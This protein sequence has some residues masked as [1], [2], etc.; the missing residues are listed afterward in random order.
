VE[1]RWLTINRNGLL[2][3]LVGIVLGAAIT[4][5]YMERKQAQSKEVFEHKN[6]C[7]QVAQ[8][9]EKEHDEGTYQLGISVDMLQ[10]E[11]S[12]ERNSCVAELIEEASNP[13]FKTKTYWVVDLLSAE[14]SFIG[15]CDE[16][17][18][19]CSGTFDSEMSSKQDAQFAEFRR[20]RSP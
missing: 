8:R 12:P 14:K 1:M 7:L 11:Y 16:G 9:Y 19:E 4:T 18:G 10:V 20:G 15:M 13:A 2:L 6:R 5:A 17:K 3:L